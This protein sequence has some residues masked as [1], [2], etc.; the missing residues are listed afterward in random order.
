MPAVVRTPRSAAHRDQSC[1]AGPD[2]GDEVPLEQQWLASD[3]AD[4][5]RDRR[6][7]FSA[8]LSIEAIEDLSDQ[9]SS[10]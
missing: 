4:E 10:L 8:E 9:V 7:H 6:P 3:A 1:F 2:V 5:P